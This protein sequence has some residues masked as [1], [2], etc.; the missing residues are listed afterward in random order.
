MG[1]MSEL[2][3]DLT[4][5]AYNK[6]ATLR[7]RQ[8]NRRKLIESIKLVKTKIKQKQK[9]K[10]TLLKKALEVKQGRW[11]P[12]IKT[13]PIS[14]TN[15][16]PNNF[17]SSLV[18]NGNANS[19]HIFQTKSVRELQN[20]QGSNFIKSPMTR[21]MCTRRNGTSKK[22]QIPEN[23]STI[24]NNPKSYKYLIKSI[25]R[26]ARLVKKHMNQMHDNS[27]K[28][29]YII[30]PSLN[31]SNNDKNSFTEDD[32]VYKHGQRQLIIPK[33]RNQILRK[34]NI[35]KRNDLF[36]AQLFYGSGEIRVNSKI[37]LPI[38]YNEVGHFVSMDIIIDQL[39]ENI[40]LT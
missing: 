36:Q 24:L 1:G 40:N 31:I 34:I 33:M 20:H 6:V 17:A 3:I 23:L 4:Q 35:K 10:Q 13:C 11:Q 32:I 21:Q 2:N 29:I 25:M 7:R 8:L 19:S 5:N 22:L 38:N 9:K 28:M 18:R 39:I 15:I 26:L 12:E 37:T 14:L 30:Y 16:Y 27:D